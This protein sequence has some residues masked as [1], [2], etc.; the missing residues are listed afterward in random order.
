[1]KTSLKKK[2]AFCFKD[3]WIFLLQT[4]K[5]IMKIVAIAPCI[6]TSELK[7]IDNIKM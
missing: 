4:N 1:M 3:V 7:H 5:K 6:Y 2:F